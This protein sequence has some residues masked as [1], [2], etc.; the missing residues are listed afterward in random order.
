MPES[1]ESSVDQGRK[2]TT[3]LYES[4]SDQLSG[5]EPAKS[6]AAVD[7]RYPVADYYSKWLDE[8][9]LESVRT[10]ARIHFGGR[11]FLMAGQVTALPSTT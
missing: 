4:F 1:Q 7:D 11:R 5:I 10:V 3:A 8:G 2:R 6:E 9:I